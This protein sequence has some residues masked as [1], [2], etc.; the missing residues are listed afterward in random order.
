MHT[1][2]DFMKIDLNGLFNSTVKEIEI[3]NSFDLSSI[4][5][6]GSN[7]IKDMVQIKGKLYCKADV[8]YLDATISFK[9][10]GSCD[11]CAEDVEKD[12]S[13][14]I[15]KI[16]VEQL[17]NQDDDEDYIVVE[18]RTLDLEELVNEEVSLAL[19]TKLLCKDDCAGL[20]AQCGT[21]LNVKKCDCKKEVDPRLSA[22]LQL[23]DEE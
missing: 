8:V 23:L 6:S 21:N 20:C 5:Y 7:P 2:G 17:Q 9:F 18:N 22:L 10:Y 13:I 14:K 12:F 16:I 3:N 1:R 11:R 15:N 4:S 19:P